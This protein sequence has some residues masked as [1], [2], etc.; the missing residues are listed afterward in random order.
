V[1]FAQY[2]VSIPIGYVF[3]L[4]TKNAFAQ[5]TMFSLLYREKEFADDFNE[6]RP[7]IA[8]L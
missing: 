6:S 8:L 3:S 7:S 1:F 5:Q 4:D 2:N